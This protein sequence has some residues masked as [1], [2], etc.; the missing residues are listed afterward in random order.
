MRRAWNRSG[1][2]LEANACGMPAIALAEGGV[3]ETVVDGE[4]GRLV[5]SPSQMAAVL[6]RFVNDPAEA[7]ALGQRGAAIVRER[8]TLDAATSRLEGHLRQAADM[9]RA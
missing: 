6:D 9:R 8:W 5:D 1:W 3:R 2:R 7:R 4:N